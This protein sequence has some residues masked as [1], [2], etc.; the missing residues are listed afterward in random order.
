AEDQ[1]FEIGKAQ[2][3]ASGTDVSIFAYGHMVWNAVEAAKTLAEQGISCEVVN[4]HTIKPLDE[5]FILKSVAKTGCAVVAE[6]HQKNGGLGDA[7][8][9]VLATNQPAPLEIVAVNDSF[10]ESGKPEQLL[11]KYGLSPSDIVKAT[12]KVLNRKK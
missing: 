4:I 11:E 12:L 3:L 7:I 6:E 5:E 8:A 2:L 1:T 9:H 10:G